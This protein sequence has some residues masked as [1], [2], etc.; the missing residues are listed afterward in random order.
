MDFDLETYWKRLRPA[1]GSP[2]ARGKGWSL[3]EAIVRAGE[4]AN[5]ALAAKFEKGANLDASKV[6]TVSV[7]CFLEAWYEELQQGDTVSLIGVVLASRD[8]TV[9]ELKGFVQ[10]L[11]TSLLQR[12]CDFPSPSASGLQAL[13]AI[14][15]A[16]RKKLAPDYVLSRDLDGNLVVTFY[17]PQAAGR[18][19]SFTLDET[20][21]GI[22]DAGV[23]SM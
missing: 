21:E 9:D 1:R 5:A 7:Q 19:V 20:F 4:K 11:P 2:E 8:L 6:A 12:I 10:A 13:L 16:R 18:A 23:I 17:P 14:E 3:R 15:A 22:V